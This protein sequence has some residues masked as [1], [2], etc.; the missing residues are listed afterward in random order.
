VTRGRHPRSPN[1]S[2]MSNSRIAS[3]LTVSISVRDHPIISTLLNQF[4]YH[5][6]RSSQG[7]SFL[8]EGEPLSLVLPISKVF[9][10]SSRG[11]KAKNFPI[12]TR[13]R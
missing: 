1:I 12:P 9:L 7:S 8:G 13:R 4:C 11:F 3:F 10:V 6:P 5:T 2:T